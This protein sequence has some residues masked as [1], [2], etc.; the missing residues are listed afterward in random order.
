[1]SE[2]ADDWNAVRVTRAQ[3]EA[4]RARILLEQQPERD[5]DIAEIVEKSCG[6]RSAEDQALWDKVAVAALN[7]MLSC[8]V[9]PQSGAD[10]FARDAAFL[11]DAFMAERAKR[12]KD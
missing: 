12:M 7:G 2:L 9:Q 5:P 1:M 11:A 10:M 6:K 8:T 3:L 4:E